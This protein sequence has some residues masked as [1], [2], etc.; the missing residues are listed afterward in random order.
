MLLSKLDPTG[1]L[2]KPMMALLGDDPA[3]QERLTQMGAKAQARAE[4][5]R[6]EA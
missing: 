2:G 5:T 3:I 1:T 6:R 4:R